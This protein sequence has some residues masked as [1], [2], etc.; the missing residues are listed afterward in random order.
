MEVYALVQ[1]A[2]LTT[3]TCNGDVVLR[4]S[5]SSICVPFFALENEASL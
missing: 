1:W 3:E 2:V 5:R 4:E